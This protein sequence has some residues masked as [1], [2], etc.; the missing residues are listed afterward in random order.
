MSKKKFT[1]GLEDLFGIALEDDLQDASPL[2]VRT[3]TTK[4]KTATTA[5]KKK[6]KSRRKASGK[7]FTSDLESLFQISVKEPSIEEKSTEEEEKN[8][9]KKA[10]ARRVRRKPVSGLDALLRQT[11]HS[12]ARPEPSSASKK[13]VTFVFDK[14]KLKK[15]KTIARS[16]KAYLKDIIGDIISEFITRY[17]DQ[18]GS[19]PDI[20]FK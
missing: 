6:R 12:T 8:A 19:I 2:L 15:L 9:R 17:E 5:E 10:L 7:N 16:E 20:Q 3:G 13:R 14:S 11:L 4:E 1:D 18:N